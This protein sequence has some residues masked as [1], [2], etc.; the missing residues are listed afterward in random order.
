[1][2]NFTGKTALVAGGLGLI[3]RPTVK[4]LKEMSCGVFIA[5]TASEEPIDVVDYHCISNYV[6]DCVPDYFINCVYPEHIQDHLASFLVPATIMAEAMWKKGSGVIVNL[7]SIYGVI[8]PR[9][10]I[11][12]YTGIREPSQEYCD[13]KAEIIEM[14][15]EMATAFSPRVRIHCIIPGGV[16]DSQSATFQW[17]YSQLTLNRKMVSAESVAQAIVF[18]CGC[19]DAGI[20][21]FVDGGITV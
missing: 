1:M 12:P 20:F 11:Y 2:F 13:V 14:T 4:L 15:R 7:S 5:D 16:E 8:K 6:S 10:W 21:Q 19:E 9:Y 18:V 3:G 17:R